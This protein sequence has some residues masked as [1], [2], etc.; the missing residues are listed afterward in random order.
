MGAVSRGSSALKAGVRRLVRRTGFDIVRSTDNRGGV[1]DFIPFEATIRAARASGLSVGDHIDAVMNG[2]PGATQFTIDELRSLGV[3]AAGPRTVLEIGPGSGRYLEKT[4]KECSPERYE[5]YET[6]APWAGYLVETFGAVARPAEGSSLA[7][8]PDASIDLVQAHKVFNTVT[9][10][11][12]SRYF[13]EM[14]RVARP[15][16]RI[17][18]D[19]MTE[20]CLDPATVRTWA[21]RGGAGHDTYPTPIPRGTCVDLFGTLGCTLEASFLAPMG[22]ATTEVLVFAKGA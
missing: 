9:F 5:I 22:V 7:P 1:D 13:F 18:F 16:G 17:V 14:A 3:Y 4:L 21:T 10:L 20:R 2:T 19:V 11:C 8:T 6:A 15:G 12:A